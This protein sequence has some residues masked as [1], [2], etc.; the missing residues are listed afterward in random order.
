MSTWHGCFS[1][2]GVLQKTRRLILHASPAIVSLSAAREYI[3]W[4]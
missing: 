2:L 1:C 3:Q 4:M